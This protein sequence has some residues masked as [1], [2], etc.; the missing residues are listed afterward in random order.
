MSEF[1]AVAKASEIQ[2]GGMKGLD[3]NGKHILLA[4][5]G[6]RYYAISNICSHQKCELSDGK[7]EGNAVKCICHGS[8]FDVTSGSVLSGPAEKPVESY[9]VKVE[10][11]DI[12]IGIQE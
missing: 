12:T 7:L 6:G 10:G 4:N 9:E 8:K 11:D 5:I 1:V 2:D 3:V